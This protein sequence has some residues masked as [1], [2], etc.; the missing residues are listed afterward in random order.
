VYYIILNRLVV[1]VR[2][3]VNVDLDVFLALAICEGAG[4]E[5]ENK[6]R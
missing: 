1:V 2:A 3:D 4:M 6:I 5:L